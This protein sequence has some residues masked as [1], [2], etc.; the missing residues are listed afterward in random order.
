MTTSRLTDDTAFTR[1]RDLMTVPARPRLNSGAVADG[2]APTA[3]SLATG[4]ALEPRR[5]CQRRRGRSAGGRSEA[6][7]PDSRAHPHATCRSTAARIMRP[8]PVHVKT[9]ITTRK[10]LP[11][12]RR[13]PKPKPAGE[14]ERREFNTAYRR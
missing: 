13:C 14:A 9:G 6:G 12:C 5:D 8:L 2:R 10:H 7:D 3:V 1:Y 4:D 11:K